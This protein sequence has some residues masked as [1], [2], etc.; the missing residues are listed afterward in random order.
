MSDRL[1]KE[2]E[3]E[4]WTENKE[5]RGGFKG[6]E[7]EGDLDRAYR[8]SAREESQRREGAEAADGRREEE[9]H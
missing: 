7:T 1:G 9:R 6:K 3:I 2:A 8:V 4:I 5:G